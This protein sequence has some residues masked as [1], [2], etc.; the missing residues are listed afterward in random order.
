MS[1]NV[2]NRD[3]RAM[4]L[5]AD[6]FK[7][8]V[9]NGEAENFVTI[10]DDHVMHTAYEIT[11]VLDESVKERMIGQI[12]FCKGLRDG[13]VIALEARKSEATEDE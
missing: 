6:L 11:R 12:E 3:E 9:D 2:I 5:A 13:V 10:L 4:K 1:K 7:T 8:L